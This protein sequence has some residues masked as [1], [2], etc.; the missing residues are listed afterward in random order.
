MKKINNNID[1]E[2]LCVCINNLGNASITFN[3]DNKDVPLKNLN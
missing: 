3:R 1:K 2:I